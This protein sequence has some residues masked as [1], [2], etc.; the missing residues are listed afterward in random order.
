MGR[1]TITALLTAAAL[2]AAV[3]GG[4][5]AA[6]DAP[7]KRS[8]DF[9]KR[10]NES[11]ARGVE[12]LRK[13]QKSDGSYSSD[14]TTWSGG[15]AFVYLALRVCKV[16]ADDATAVKTFEAMRREYQTK[17]PKSD[18]EVDTDEAATYCMALAEHGTPTGTLDVNGE[19]KYVLSAEDAAWMKELVKFLEEMQKPDGSFAYCRELKKDKDED[20]GESQRALLGLKA[21]SRAGVKTKNEVW[22]KAMQSFFDVQETSGP[23]VPR[24]RPEGAKGPAKFDHAR[25]F[26]SPREKRSDLSVFDWNVCD[27]I[28]S[29]VICR[30]ELSPDP[31][32]RH[33]SD[34]KSEQSIRD[35]LA[36]LGQDLDDGTM[37]SVKKART[38]G[39]DHADYV[40]I[41]AMERACDL[42]GVD[43]VGTHD[44]Y[45]EGAEYVMALQDAAGSWGRDHHTKGKEPMPPGEVIEATCSALLFLARGTPYGGSGAV[46]RALDD[47]DIN[48]AVAPSLNEK[49]FGDFLDLVLSRW[50][51]SSDPGVKDRLFAKATAVGPRIVAPSVDRLASDKDDVRASA[52]ALLQ[53]A[54]GLDHGYN[55]AAAPEAREKAVTAWREWWS[56]NETTLHYD[57]GTGRLIP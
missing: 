51:R 14:G 39:A 31:K 16:P 56:A 48:F 53:R 4:D 26:G 7:F 2:L 45:G 1:T 29:V 9:V 20:S 35:A 42:A 38:E 13:A 40:V 32:K 57:A 23:K 5:A 11:I 52:F 18:D 37:F 30:G 55:P 22:L 47:T 36:W 19:P 15:P 28:A 10:V 41:Y 24:P 3:D 50:R 43:L 49:D 8:P 54:T 21:A 27:G 33:A 12:W 44:W 46:T 6:E 34:A 17:R 25:G